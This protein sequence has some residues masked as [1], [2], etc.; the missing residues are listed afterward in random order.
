MTKNIER[1]FNAYPDEHKTLNA[2]YFV[3]RL[4]FD[5]AI[6]ELRNLAFW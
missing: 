6:F 2:N 4:N 5:S 3:I 1:A